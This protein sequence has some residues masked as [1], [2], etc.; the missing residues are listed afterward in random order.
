MAELRQ[1]RM[2][3][4]NNSHLDAPVYLLGDMVWYRHP[5]ERSAAFRPNWVAPH[6]VRVREGECR[7]RLWTGQ[8]EYGAPVSLIKRYLGPGFRWEAVAII[9]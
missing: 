9:L 5:V 7:Y 8:R 2:D 4:W 6:R 3:L 1:A